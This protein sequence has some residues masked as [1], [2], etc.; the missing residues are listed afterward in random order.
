MVKAL[1]AVRSGSERVKNKNIRPFAGSSLLEIKIK[2]L[3]R[4]ACIDGIVVNSNDPEMLAVARALNCETVL[5][6]QIYADAKT[7]MSDVYVNMAEN[8]NADIVA[9]CNVT[10]PLIEDSSIEK[11]IS[12]YREQKIAHTSINTAHLIKEFMYLNGRAL[13]YDPIHQPRSQ[14]L[15]N[16]FAL[17]FA[18]NVL[19]R[20]DMIKFKNIITPNHLLLP[21]T[22]AES[23]DIDSELD[24]SVAEFLYERKMEGCL[25]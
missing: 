16:I 18:V 19:S 10:N 12:L 9:Y 5:R 14:D 3:S 1:I 17:N 13:N 20:L 25:C 11:A 24:F 7:S 15:P 21:V 22:E 8:F 4:V 6:E 2:Q 23:I